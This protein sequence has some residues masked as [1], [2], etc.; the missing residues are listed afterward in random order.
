ML[1]GP[2][3]LPPPPFIHLPSRGSWDSTQNGKRFAAGCEE[4][5]EQLVSDAG[6]APSSAHHQFDDG[7][8]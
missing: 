1:R 2:N 8:L 3:L 7:E 5:V 6:V 4:C